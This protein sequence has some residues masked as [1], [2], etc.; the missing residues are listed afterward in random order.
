LTC[1]EKIAAKKQPQISEPVGDHEIEDHAHRE[2]E[3]KRQ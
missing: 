3:Q 1:I 2:K